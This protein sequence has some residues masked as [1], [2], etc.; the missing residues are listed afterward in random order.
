MAQFATPDFVSYV[1]TGATDKGGAVTVG[2]DGTIYLT[3]TTTGTFAGQ[4][5]KHRRMSTTPSR[6]RWRRR[7]AI[8]WTRQF[9]GAD[10]TIDR[11]RHCHRSQGSSVLDA[12][13]LPRGTITL[14]QSVDL[15]SQTTLRAGDSFQIQFEGDRRAHRDHHHRP[16]RDAAVAR[17]QDQHTA[18]DQRQGI[19]QLCQRRRRTEDRG[20]SRR[21]AK[22]VAGPADFDAL[23]R[24]GITPGTLTS[25]STATSS[26]TTSSTSGTTQAFG[27][28]LTGTFDLTTTTGANLA[29]SQLLG[30]LSQLQ[31]A[32]QKT[33][34]PP[35]APAGPGITNGTVSPYLQQQLAAGNLALSLLA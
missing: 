11:R 1:G 25:A 31:T 15:T 5:R 13:G 9:G 28:G 34:A 24:L 27:L 29:R 17:H 7:A 20:Q 3:G 30:V 16:G 33:N 22:L 8:N 12:L 19:G 26:S 10:G 4:T 35:S 21:D 6:P 18:A 32:Y 2:A 23:A 14:N